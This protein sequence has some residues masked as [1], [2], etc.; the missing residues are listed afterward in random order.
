MIKNMRDFCIFLLVLYALVVSL[1]IRTS[2]EQV[3]YWL[4]KRDIAYDSI[5]SEYVEDCD[6][7]EELE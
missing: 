2:P 5:W 1:W 6:C 3:G 4:A 7:T